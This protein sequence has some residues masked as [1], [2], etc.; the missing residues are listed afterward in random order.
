VNLEKESIP[1]AVLHTKRR[2]NRSAIQNPD[3]IRN[4]YSIS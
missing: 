2:S 4:T 3:S 1:Q